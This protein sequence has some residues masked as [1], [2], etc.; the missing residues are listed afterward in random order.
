MQIRNRGSKKS[1]NAERNRSTKKVPTDIGY[2]QSCYNLEPFRR[3]N[4]PANITDTFDLSWCN[5][6]LP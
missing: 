5:N 1:S 6:F 4:V 2:G 3:P